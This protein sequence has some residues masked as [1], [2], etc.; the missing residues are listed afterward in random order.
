M[1]NFGM[2]RENVDFTRVRGILV[3]ELGCFMVDEMAGNVDFTGFLR[4][5]CRSWM[6][7]F[8]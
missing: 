4:S 3:G 2:F 8:G 6:E 7:D 1:F 5:Q